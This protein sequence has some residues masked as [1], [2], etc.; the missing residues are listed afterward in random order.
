MFIGEYQHNIDKKGRINVPTKFRDGLFKTFYLTK[1]LDN[2]LFCFPEVEWKVFE[3]KLKSLPLTNRNARA[4]VRLFFAGATECSLDKQGRILVPQILREHSLIEKEVMI[5]GVGTRVE[6]WSLDK[7]NDYI[8]PDN[9][10]YDEIAEHM[11]DL[12]I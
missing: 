6:I 9:I 8:D 2:S 7:W 12:G 11:A 10:S 4:F 3:D 5:I 1:G